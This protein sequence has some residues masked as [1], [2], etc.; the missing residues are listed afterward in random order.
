MDGRRDPLASAPD[1]SRTDR[2]R[3]GDGPRGA[4]PRGITMP[5]AVIVAT[6][7]T[8]IGRAF[9]GSLVDVRPDDLVADVIA[10]ALAADAA[11]GGHWR[12]AAGVQ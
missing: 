2:G 5:E 7:R 1:G 4:S 9:K 11:Q 10:A 8:P 12:A 3:T 6:A